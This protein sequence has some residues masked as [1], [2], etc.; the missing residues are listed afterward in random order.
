MGEP[1][2]R[3]SEAHD[4]TTHPRR[5]PGSGIGRLGVAAALLLAVLA[6]GAAGTAPAATPTVGAVAAGSAAGG[7]GGIAVAGTDAARMD[8]VYIEESREV[9]YCGRVTDGALSIERAD[10]VERG[11]DF[12]RFDA[13]SCR[14]MGRGATANVHTHPGGAASLSATDRR[15]LARDDYR[16]VC[17][18]HGAVAV[19]AGDVPGLACYEDDDGAVTRVPVELAR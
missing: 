8:E 9:V 16:Y 17:V 7:S 18:Q 3:P 5:R 6:A 13:T 1:T 15:L 14:D 4:M 11:R 19:D 10:V 2:V 12:A